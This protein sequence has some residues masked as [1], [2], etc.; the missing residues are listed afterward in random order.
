MTS[1]LPSTVRLRTVGGVVPVCVAVD[2]VYHHVHAP[3]EFQAR[4]AVAMLHP[5]AAMHPPRPTRR[6]VAGRADVVTQYVLAARSMPGRAVKVLIPS[7]HVAGPS[8]AEA[9]V[10]GL[11]DEFEWM[12]T[13]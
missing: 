11:P 6:E 3:V 1:W 10:P 2:G 4:E 9:G 12:V 7:A 5:A 13:V 8:A